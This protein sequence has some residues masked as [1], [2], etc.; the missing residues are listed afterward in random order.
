M[1][2]VCYKAF[3]HQQPK[4]LHCCIAPRAVPID[5]A[6]MH[7]SLL[8]GACDGYARMQCAPALALLHLGPGLSNGLSNLHNARRAGSPVVVLVGDMPSWHKPAGEVE[9]YQP[10]IIP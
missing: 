8:T 2:E 1:H 3:I 10:I 4:H 6:Q 9:H 7:G 5:T